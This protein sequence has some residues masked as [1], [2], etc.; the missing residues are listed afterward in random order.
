MIPA[1]PFILLLAASFV[2]LFALVTVR[3]LP[4]VKR[5]K[6]L[7]VLAVGLTI[8]AGAKHIIGT[9]TLDVY[10]RDAGSYPT[11]D[12]WHVAAT[13]TF[14]AMPDSTLIHIEAQWIHDSV[15][16]FPAALRPPTTNKF[17]LAEF[18]YYAMPTN[19]FIVGATNYNIYVYADWTEPA[20]ATNNVLSIRGLR[21]LGVDWDDETI[22]TVYRHFELE[23]TD[24]NED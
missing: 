7:T 5:K 2:M 24:T 13:K 8:Y 14:L 17:D 21:A 23:R 16:N 18:P 1:G 15:T 12:V 20:S 6:A 3:V 11:N 19:I 4:P 22:T 9:S 10:L